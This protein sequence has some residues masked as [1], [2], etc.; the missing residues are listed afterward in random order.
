M[1]HVE[2]MEPDIR[3]VTVNSSPYA[4]GFY[5]KIGFQPVGPE[6]KADGIRVTSMRL[7]F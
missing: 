5:E 6:K 1:A 2:T 4:V 3:A 7:T